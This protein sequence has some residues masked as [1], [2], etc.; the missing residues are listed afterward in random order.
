MKLSQDFLKEEFEFLLSFA[1]SCAF[2]QLGQLKT[3]WYT[4]CLH[5]G[6]NPDDE[7]ARYDLIVLYH[8]TAK[9]EH[10]SEILANTAHFDGKSWFFGVMSSY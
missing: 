6:H 2:K 9:N 5:Q 1:G 8:T 3:M 10:F 4:Y 7:C